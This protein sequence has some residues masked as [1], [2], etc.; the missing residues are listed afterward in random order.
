MSLRKDDSQKAPIEK[1]TVFEEIIPNFC[2]RLGFKAIDLIRQKTAKKARPDHLESIDSMVTEDGTAVELPDASSSD[3]D[4]PESW[5]F[6]EIYT[7]CQELLSPLQ[8]ELIFDLYVAQNYTVKDLV[9]DSKR[10]AHFGITADKSA[11]T[12]RKR[13]DDI[14][15]P[16]LAQLALELSV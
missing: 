3:L 8:W 14:V 6:E 11:S 10:L 13:V 7:R 16:A 9:A 12:L 4:R 5:R 1:L 2:R 15:N